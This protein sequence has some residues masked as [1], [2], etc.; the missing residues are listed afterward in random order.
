MVLLLVNGS[1]NCANGSYRSN[2]VIPTAVNG[3]GGV[4]NDKRKDRDDLE[5]D[6]KPSAIKTM[7]E[8]VGQKNVVC[9]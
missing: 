1:S 4:D 6:V 8:E 7:E 3:T 2:G 9:Q 5:T